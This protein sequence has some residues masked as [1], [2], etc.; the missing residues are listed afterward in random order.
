MKLSLD[1]AGTLNIEFEKPER[2]VMEAVLEASRQQYAADFDSLPEVLQKHWRG[3]LF[4]GRPATIPGAD[5]AS[6]DLAEARLAWRSERLEVVEKW[7]A[8]GGPFGPKGNGLLTLRP[9]EIDLFF[10]ILNDR[11]LSL[12]A[13]Y[14]INEDLMAADIEAIQP[15]ELQQAVWEV[16]LLAFV[17]ESCLQC[18][19]EWK[20]E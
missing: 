13:L 16:H 10:S 12:A 11:R 5:T 7:L 14:S 15:Q 8:L 18:I 19:Q 1:K 4:S 2:K 3:R 9:D 6:D 20:E 17:M